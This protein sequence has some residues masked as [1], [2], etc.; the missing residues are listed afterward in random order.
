MSVE[1]C[2]EFVLEYL[3]NN[4]C[5]H[6][7]SHDLICLEFHHRNPEEK[8]YNIADLRAQG[9]LELLKEEIKKCDVLCVAC[10]RKLTAFRGE[11]WR[12]VIVSEEEWELENFDNDTYEDFE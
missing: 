12:S 1:K 4:P 3:R 2:N 9:K 6:C 7:Q 11:W 8:S 10:H 5:L